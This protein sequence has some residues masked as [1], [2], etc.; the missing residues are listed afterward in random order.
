M[1]RLLFFLALALSASAQETM[2]REVFDPATD[3]HVE[4]LAL[5]SKPAP[6]GYFPVRVKIAN[7]LKSERMI[8][9]DFE[10][11]DDY[12]DNLKANSSFSLTSAAGKSVTRDI[13]VPLSP[14]GSS[15][16]TR[17]NVTAR[18]SGT[19]GMAANSIR[20]NH[21]GAHPAVLLSESLFTPN[22]SALDAEVNAKSTSG[23]RSGSNEFAGKFDPKQLPA[24]WLAFS[25]YDSLIL[26][27]SDWSDIPPGARNAV[28]SWVRLGGQLVIYSTS[29]TTAASMMLARR[30]GL[31]KYRDFID[32]FGF[33]IGCTGRG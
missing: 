9:L 21:D 10:C 8:R 1:L 32:I 20:S 16:G 27:D 15:S 7:N 24:D 19:L 22:A 2:I 14:P 6:G 23:Y 12:N 18:L 31:W 5:F 4:V 33:E 25:G 26:T 11:S 13:L 3:T 29:S 28:L 17:P 30:A